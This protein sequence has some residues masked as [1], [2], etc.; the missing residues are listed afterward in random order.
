MNEA[1]TPGEVRLNWKR[2]KDRGSDGYVDHQ[3]SGTMYVGFAES[4][5]HTPSIAIPVDLREKLP[6]GV[7]GEGLDVTRAGFELGGRRH[8]CIV[9]SCSSNELERVFSE[10]TASL[11]ERLKDGQ[12][13]ISAI[14]TVIREYRAL[15]R[16]QRPSSVSREAAMGLAGELLVLRTMSGFFNE[17][18]KTWNG[19][20][21]MTHDFVSGQ[22]AIEVKTTSH[23]AEPSFEVANVSQLYPS[24]GGELFLVHHVLI[25][26]PQGGITVS[27]LADQVRSGFS[28][29]EGFDERLEAIGFVRTASEPWDQHV[30]QLTHT[31]MYQ[32][33]EGF[34]R[35][36]EN[37]IEEA[38]A[39]VSDVRYKIHLT[40]AADYRLNDQDAVNQVY[41]HME[42]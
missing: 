10:L 42:I 14:T 2:A 32:V 1:I 26:N 3:V 22:L 40:Q 17:A 23:E 21:G 9:L 8:N 13:P 27:V 25:P 20:L 4:S 38:P 29:P 11:V 7:A 39:G 5:N 19:P 35:M 36:P 6:E 41:A 12:P 31:A 15:L 16:R 33:V 30:F 18:W 28:N 37:I 24:E 34:P